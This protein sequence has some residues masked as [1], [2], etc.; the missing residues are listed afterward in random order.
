MRKE[1]FEMIMI[2]EIRGNNKTIGSIS[3]FNSSIY[4]MLIH[5]KNIKL[6]Q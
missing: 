1:Q 3:T 5:E 6:P 2:F 4:T